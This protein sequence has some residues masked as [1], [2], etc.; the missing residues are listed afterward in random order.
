MTTTS[1][2]N[3]NNNNSNNN[4][5]TITTISPVTLHHEAPLSSLLQ[6]GLDISLL[7]SSCL[8]SHTSLIFTLGTVVRGSELVSIMSDAFL[9]F[10]LS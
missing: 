7:F 2:N 1:A 9:T 8:V 4:N 3:I 5:N 10:E 6:L